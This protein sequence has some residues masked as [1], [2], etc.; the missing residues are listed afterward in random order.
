MSENQSNLNEK[1]F[2]E[3]TGESIDEK[4]DKAEEEDQ[5]DFNKWFNSYV[6]N[7]EEQAKNEKKKDDEPTNNEPT[8]NASYTA[9][10]PLD[11]HPSARRECC[12]L[13]SVQQKHPL[14]HISDI[15]AA[16]VSAHILL[17]LPNIP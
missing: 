1:D 11:K 7:D 15:D 4:L 6:N 3:L 9:D 2:T 10:I 5:E 12:V 13:P 17:F 16:S 8:N 14:I